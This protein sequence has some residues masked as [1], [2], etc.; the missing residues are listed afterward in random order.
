MLR[1][2]QKGRVWSALSQNAKTF[3]TY[4]CRRSQIYITILVEGLSTFKALLSESSRD[5]FLC[6]PVRDIQIYKCLTRLR[7]FFEWRML[8]SWKFILW[9]IFH[10]YRLP[11][12]SKFFSLESVLSYSSK[13]LA[14]DRRCVQMCTVLSRAC[15]HPLVNHHPLI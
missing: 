10:N 4:T 9:T 6:R 1:P 5:L 3:P 15:H 8:K 7:G 12:L 11:R 13:S 14:L 2:N